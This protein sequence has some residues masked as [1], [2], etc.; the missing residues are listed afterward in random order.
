M[1]VP[2]SI[3]G[4]H[5]LSALDTGALRMYFEARSA[6][7]GGSGFAHGLYFFEENASEFS[8]KDMP[9]RVKLKGGKQLGSELGGQRSIFSVQG[10]TAHNLAPAGGGVDARIALT[11]ETVGAV[12]ECVAQLSVSGL[13]DKSPKD[14]RVSF[15]TRVSSSH[16]ASVRFGRVKLVASTEKDAAA[17][18]AA[19]KS[20][21]L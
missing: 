4:W 17:I 10:A 1:A 18:L 11:T 20:A 19:L 5:L 2:V 12:P 14:I 9:D 15:R 3:K 13:D 16:T 8:I 21:L 6:M 7:P